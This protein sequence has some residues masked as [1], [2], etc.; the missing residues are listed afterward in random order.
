MGDVIRPDHWEERRLD[1]VRTLVGSLLR[2]IVK[3][4]L[5][6]Q[7]ILSE[8][9]ND[10]LDIGVFQSLLDDAIRR[11]GLQIDQAQMQG[12]AR[13]VW[14]MYDRHRTKQMKNDRD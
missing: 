8:I 10:N 4:S 3:Q 7:I 9:A 12:V 11:E 13:D 6:D 14:L 5:Q 1:I 2:S